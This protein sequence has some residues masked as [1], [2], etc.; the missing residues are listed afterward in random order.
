MAKFFP[1]YANM[2]QV[3]S[4]EWAAHVSDFRT[5]QTESQYGAYSIMYSRLSPNGGYAKPGYVVAEVHYAPNDE[6]AYFIRG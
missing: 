4:D 2:R 1:D 5:Y 3:T 6:K